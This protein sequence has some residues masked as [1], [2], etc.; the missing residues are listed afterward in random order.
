MNLTCD[1]DQYLL[2]LHFGIPL[3]CHNHVQGT[4]QF[5]TKPVV[6][7]K[8][9]GSSKSTQVELHVKHALQ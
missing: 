8:E 2:S 4:D 3:K 5:N 1:D 6:R 7:N 9:H